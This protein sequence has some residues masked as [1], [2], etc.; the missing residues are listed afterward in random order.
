[1]ILR[2]AKKPKKKRGSFSVKVDHEEK[3]K[4]DERED[5]SPL[6]SIL[7]GISQYDKEEAEEK[8]A[9]TKSAKKVPSEKKFNPTKV[10]WGATPPPFEKK[11]KRKLKKEGTA[12][13]PE[14]KVQLGG[15]GELT[16]G[17]AKSEVRVKRKYTK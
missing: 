6:L 16:V 1:M 17:E 5:T 10:T 13:V 8:K 9:K 11:K 4:E 2:R 7:K 15:E 3:D 12:I 14:E